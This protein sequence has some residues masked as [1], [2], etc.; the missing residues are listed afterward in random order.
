M[1]QEPGTGTA[2]GNRVIR[3]RR[4][5]DGIAGAAGELGSDVPDHLEPARHKIECLGD[6]LTDPA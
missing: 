6:V 4:R 2:A 3:R 5:D 1:G